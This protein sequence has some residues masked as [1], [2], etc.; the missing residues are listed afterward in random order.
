MT[1]REVFR[2]PIAA[3]KV[4][5]AYNAAVG[6]QVFLADFIANRRFGLHQFHICEDTKN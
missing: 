4:M 3:M 5:K 6:F 2:N 1:S